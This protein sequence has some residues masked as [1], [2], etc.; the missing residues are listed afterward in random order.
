M[1]VCLLVVYVSSFRRFHDLHDQGS[2]LCLITWLLKATFVFKLKREQTVEAVMDLHCCDFC[3]FVYYFFFFLFSYFCFVLICVLNVYVQIT[4]AQSGA[5]IMNNDRFSS[6]VRSFVSVH[7]RVCIRE[8]VSHR[9]DGLTMM[10]NSFC[11]YACGFV[12]TASN[13]NPNPV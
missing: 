6:R 5:S 12:T 7:S 13:T 11:S 4:M 9:P 2:R 8:A 3:L 1:L 10:H